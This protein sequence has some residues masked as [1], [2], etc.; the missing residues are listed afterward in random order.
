[1]TASSST[2]KITPSSW[3]RGSEWRRWDLHI[4]T[5]ESRLGDSFVGTSWEDYLTALEQAAAASKISVIGVTDYMT[6]DG[7]EK[8]YVEKSDNSRLSTVDL[9]IPNI[10]FRIMHLGVFVDQNAHG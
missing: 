8:L 6:I 4:H 10:E 1:M 2:L 3:P 7:Y 5:P 9:L